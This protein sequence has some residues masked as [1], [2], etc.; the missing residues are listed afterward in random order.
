MKLN[1]YP[2]VCYPNYLLLSKFGRIKCCQPVYVNLAIEPVVYHLFRV[3]RH[4]SFYWFKVVDSFTASYWKQQGL[5]AMKTLSGK[6][7]SS[8]LIRVSSTIK[9]KDEA[10]SIADMKEFSRLIIPHIQKY[11]P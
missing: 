10:M 9:G 3:P 8:A 1:P 4:Y 7:A 2:L 11:M 6:P 5:I